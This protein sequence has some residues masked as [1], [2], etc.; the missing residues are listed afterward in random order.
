LAKRSAYIGLSG[1]L[2]YD[3]KNKLNT[4]YP[5]PILEAPV[6]LMVL[7]D[8]AVFLNEIVCPKS[9]RNLDFVKFISDK[10]DIKDFL[11]ELT[12]KK[13]KNIKTR[14]GKEKNFPLRN[15]EQLQNK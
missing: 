6:G 7:Y 15:L 9:M 14:L 11:K 8:E 13:S 1:P 12:N 4:D 5:N 10:K 3:Y 2:C